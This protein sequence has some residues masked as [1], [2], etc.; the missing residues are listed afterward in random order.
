MAYLIVWPVVGLVQGQ[1]LGEI[2]EGLAWAF[3]FAGALASIT[4]PAGLLIGLIAGWFSPMVERVAAVLIG[5]LMAVAAVPQIWD[6]EKNR[7][8][9]AMAV[10][11]SALC[12][13]WI[14]GWVLRRTGG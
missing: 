3:V 8:L 5:G 2:V 14:N 12:G 9:P 7:L 13:Y 10:L 4:F 6:L 11:L 1:G